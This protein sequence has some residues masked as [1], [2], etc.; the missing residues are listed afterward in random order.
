MSKHWKWFYQERQQSI[1]YTPCPP[2]KG[3][4]LVEFVL[5]NHYYSCKNEE[6]LSGMIQTMLTASRS[7]AEGLLTSLLK[8]DFCNSDY[9]I[10]SVLKMLFLLSACTTIA[11]NKGKAPFSLKQLFSTILLCIMTASLSVSRTKGFLYFSLQALK[12]QTWV[13]KCSTVV[14]SANEREEKGQHQYKGKMFHMKCKD[15]SK[16]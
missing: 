11:N 16:C 14:A 8:T 7:R 5:K 6:H 1:N 10:F 2:G 4:H 12:Q 3:K 15:K 9:I 13:D